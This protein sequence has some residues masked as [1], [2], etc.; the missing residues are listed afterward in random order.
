MVLSLSAAKSFT[1]QEI[2]HTGNLTSEGTTDYVATLC[3][4]IP[5]APYCS[6]FSNM[7]MGA[8]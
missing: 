1:Q 5:I 8:G 6:R 4:I 3:H 2:Q 7:A